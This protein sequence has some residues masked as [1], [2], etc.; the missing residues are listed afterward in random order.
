VS[1]QV[2]LE[3][4]LG[5]Y[6][7]GGKHL[8]GPGP[9]H[10][11]LELIVKAALRAPDHGE[12][13][14]FRFTVVEGESR[15][16]LANLFESYAISTGKSKESCQIE[17]DRAL[18]IPV[19]IAVIARIDMSHPIVPAHEQWMCI[20]GAVTNILNAI[21]MLGYA[22]KMLSGGKVRDKTIIDAFCL[23]GES[24]VGWIVVGT[25]SMPVKEKTPKLAS[26]CISYF[27]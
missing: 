4:L 23:P 26:D 3:D 7:L 8:I 11:D 1:T 16:R 2:S 5:R 27:D 9:D 10:G 19:S 14:P 6:S 15:N 13:T 25:P 24:L 22:G 18:S 20:G 17:R 21:H 12:L